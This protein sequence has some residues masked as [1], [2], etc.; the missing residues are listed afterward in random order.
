MKRPI[1]ITAVWS[2]R[3]GD[4]VETLVEIAGQWHVAIRERHDGA[5]SHIAEG[6]GAD[7]WPVD[8]VTA[9]PAF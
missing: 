9:E 7:T 3:R 4:Q 5:F 6:N 8:P 1:V 2:R